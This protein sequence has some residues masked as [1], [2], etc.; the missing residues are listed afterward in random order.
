MVLQNELADEEVEHFEDIVEEL[1]M[2]A[3]KADKPGDDPS[4]DED[5]A[6][7]PS[8]P[9]S[10]DESSDKGDDDDLLGFGGLTES[11]PRV[12]KSEESSLPGGYD[13]RHRE[14][15]YWYIP[16]LPTVCMMDGFLISIGPVSQ[17]SRSCGMV[18]TQGTS[19][20]CT[21]VGFNHGQ[22][23]T[24]RCQHRIQRESIK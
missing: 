4:E 2:Q 20:A 16:F 1:D 8:P 5:E 17:Q 18:G 13:P 15:T 22:N 12:Q 14:P 7:T 6:E 24:L 10:D 9:S 21:S 11:Q 3:S 23:L 19:Y